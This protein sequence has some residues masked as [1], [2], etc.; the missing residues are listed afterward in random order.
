[1]PFCSAA[2]NGRTILAGEPRTSDPGGI[3]VPFVT[4]APAPMIEP[5]PTSAPSITI[6]FIPTRTRS[7]IVQA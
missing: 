7:R 4:N 3:L 5:L 6:A 2:V 1:M